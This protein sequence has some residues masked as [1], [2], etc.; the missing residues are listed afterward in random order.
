MKFI[1]R[2]GAELAGTIKVGGSK[3]TTLKLIAASI[4]I[5][6]TVTLE[7]APKITDVERMIEILRAL[8]GQAT[9]K[10]DKL[11]LDGRLVNQQTLPVRISQKLRGSVVFIGPLLARFGKAFLPFPGGCAI[12]ERPLTAH[13]NLFEQCGVSVE[14]IDGGANNKY[15]FSY[16]GNVPKNIKLIERSVTATENAILFGVGIKADMVIFNAA[17][18]PEIDDLIDFLCRAGANIKRISPSSIRIGKYTKLTA[19]KYHIKGD[20]IEAGT[21]LVAG[22][23]LG[24]NLT[25]MGIATDYLSSPLALL[26]ECGIKYTAANDTVSISRTDN[27]LPASITT[28]VYPAFPTDLQSPFG[29]L[30]TQAKGKSVINETLFNNRLGYL[31]ELN[32]MGANTRIVSSHRAEIYGPTPLKGTT[33][34]SL[35]LRAGA[36]MILAGLAASGTTLVKN[37]EIID[38]GYENIDQKLRR[39]GAKIKRVG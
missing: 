11:I 30:L 16:S 22:A 7:N 8:G 32:T 2:G 23:L 24:K 18:E 33:I 36:T 13:L 29:L 38:R 31:N 15:S 21:W 3:N 39:V 26:K 9:W 34:E 25:I 14:E 1:I 19:V 37:A 28:A 10:G 17:A 20:R 12:G 27:V 6:G 35:D 4:I 5:G